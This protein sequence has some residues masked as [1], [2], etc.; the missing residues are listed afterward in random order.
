[1]NERPRYYPDVETCV[2]ETL[3]KIGRRILL[4]TPLGL[5]KANHLVNEFFRRAREDPRINLHIFT[6]LSLGRPPWKGDLERR[7]LEPLSE[8]LFGDYPE[9]D[10][11]NFVRQGK[12]PPNIRVSEF[13]FQPGSFLNSPLAQQSYMSSNYTHVVRD[14]LDAGINV[15][16]QLV[17]KMDE[18]G[19]TRYSLSCNP[20]LTVDLVP[21]L[22]D[23]ERQGGKIAF[24]AQVNKN[25]P[26][27]YGDA[28]V[29]GDYFDAIVDSSK[30][31]FPLFGTPN[32]SVDTAE[33]L[34][35][36]HISALIRDG[37]TIQI[38]IGALEDAVTY[39]LKLRHGQN[40]LY[41]EILTKAHVSERF[42]KVIEQLGGTSPFRQGL[43]ASSEMLVDGF[44]ELYRNGILRRKVYQHF[45]L[46]KLLNDGRIVETVTPATLD[47]LVE[48]RV[49]SASLTSQDF[50]FLQSFGVLKP[51]LHYDEGFILLKNGIRIAADLSDQTARREIVDRCLGTQLKGGHFAHACFFLGP[52]NFYESL[53]Q[54]NRSEREQICMTGISYVNELFGQEALK[55]LQR[56]DARFVNTGLIATL[57]GA[58]ASDGLDDGRVLSGVG[59]QYNFVAMAQALEDG[60]SIMMIRSTSEEDGKLSSNIRWRYSHV[61]IPR[62]LRDVVVTEYGIADLRGRSDEQVITA[63][64]EI[65]DSRFQDELLELAKHAGKVSRHY[66]IPAQARNNRPERLKRMLAQYRERGLFPEFPF[67]TDLTI[68]EVALRKGLFALEQAIKRKKLHLP[69]LTVIRKTAIIPR[70]AHQYLERMQLDR[71][72]SV[73]ERLLQRA[74][75]YALASVNAI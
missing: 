18:N 69:R 56:K 16:V 14:V 33:Y 36:L 41:N 46:Q 71:P 48:D 64:V 50:I 53:R 52:R 55:R 23:A 65:A 43:Y 75:V 73:K 27:M 2:D 62:H 72:H 61:T 34:I 32:R 13:Y 28:S 35:A 3:S 49:I 22:R 42:S 51:D 7:F 24:L 59:G 26:F 21:R 37:G 45:A 40:D 63:L 20:D 31:D 57:T 17:S 15:L 9:L 54:M 70:Q 68:E 74:V 12:L 4:G 67:G 58:V 47:V 19:A 60:R 29:A 8:R 66:R 44:L 1:M 5:G 10:Y 6:A 25:L 39:V 11:V 30:Y 38:G